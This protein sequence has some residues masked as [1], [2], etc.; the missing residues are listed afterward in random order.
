[1][2]QSV[3]QVW[4]H[5]VFS[6]KERRPFL[7]NEQFRDEMFRMLWYHV[8]QVGCHPRRI[9]GWVD[10]VHILFAL[11]RT[12]TI[13]KLVEQVKTKTSRW[14]KK[15]PHRVGQFTWQSGYGVFSV[16]PSNLQAVIE[17]I[18]RQPE[19][20]QRVSFQEEFRQ[21]CLRHGIAIDER[22]VWD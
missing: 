3:S 18:D 16:T 11:S 5:L 4:L 14:A 6:T 13:A 21:L 15:A 10:H 20:H 8:E 2:P 22:Y 1:M 9:N 7:Q 12:I 17:Y 19:H